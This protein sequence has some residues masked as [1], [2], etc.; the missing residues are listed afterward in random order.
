MEPLNWHDSSSAIVRQQSGPCAG[1]QAQWRG[2]ASSHSHSVC[3]HTQAIRG[4]PVAWAARAGNMSAAGSL[5]F[6]LCAMPSKS[7]P[8]QSMKQ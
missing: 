3:S 1:L 4:M 5:S 7:P 8:K 6:R 2:A